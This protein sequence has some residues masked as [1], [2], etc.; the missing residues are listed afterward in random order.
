MRIPSLLFS[1]L[2]ALFIS[3][4]GE[5]QESVKKPIKRTGKE[6]SQLYCSSCHQYP[7]PDL[8]DKKSWK[9]HML[10]RMGYLLGIYPHDSIRATLIEEGLGG[11]IVESQGIFPREPRID[12]IDWQLIEEYYLSNAP[13]ALNLPDHKKITRDLSQFKVVVPEYK[14]SPPSVTM[15]DF[16]SDKQLYIGDANSKSLLVFDKDLNFIQ[17]GKIDEGTVWMEQSQN[18]LITTVMG[19][20]SPTDAPLGR[21][22]AI[23]TQSGAPKTLIDS[24]QRP[25]HTDYGDLDGDGQMD[26]VICE[27]G[28]WTGSL[29]WWKNSGNGQ[30]ERQVLRQSPGATKA[31]I[32]DLNGDNRLDIIALFAQGDEGIYA[33]YNQG[34]GQFKQERLIQFHPSFG[35]SFFNLYD[36]NGDD[37]LDIIYTAGDNADFSPIFKP[38]H[39]IRILMNDGKNQFEESFF[40]HLN[41]AYN[42]IPADYDQDGDIDIA[43]ISFFPD[44]HGQP[45]E[46]FVYLENQ[47]DFNFQAS[48]IPDPTLGRWIVMD[49]GDI[50]DDGDLDLILGSLAFEVIPKGD[51]VDKWVQ[52]GIPFIVL[53]NTLKP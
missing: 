5:T 21:I 14:L 30:F 50:D 40:Y 19:S 42:A 29:S 12:S 34:N 26:M 18:A 11:E 51:F 22:V 38:Y 25:V 13:K 6:L 23:P 7:E 37:H 48:T 41:G 8:L 53:E 31:Y 43:A 2:I 15:V 20:F 36:F 32:R 10:P 9:N 44:F 3:A 35:S 49:S 27:F 16:S 24:L 4:C 45:E 33:F 47:G 39:G 46:S 28:K 52:N 17:G 1:T